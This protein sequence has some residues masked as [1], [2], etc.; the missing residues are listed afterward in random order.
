MYGSYNTR[1]HTADILTAEHRSTRRPKGKSAGHVHKDVHTTPI[2]P[3]VYCI[4]SA[5]VSMH[6]A[7]LS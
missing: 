2:V 6:P 5:A 4:Q 1:H 3:H 7:P